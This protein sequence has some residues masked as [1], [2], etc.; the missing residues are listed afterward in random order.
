MS[1]VNVFIF[2]RNNMMVL[3]RV[4]NGQGVGV[5]N[6]INEVAEFFIANGGVM[7][8]FIREDGVR[9]RRG[10]FQPRAGID[11]EAI[12]QEQ[13]GIAYLAAWKEVLDSLPR[14]LDS[15]P[16]EESYSCEWRPAARERVHAAFQAVID[17]LEAA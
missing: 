15:L 1:M 6:D 2:S 8:G 7:G 5:F 4:D 14:S 11:R 13:A 3:E 17:S 16:V 10:C 12:E 9:Y